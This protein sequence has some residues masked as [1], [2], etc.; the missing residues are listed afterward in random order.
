MNTE[1][2]PLGAVAGC[3]HQGVVMTG[4]LIALVTRSPGPTSCDT[5]VAF[6]IARYA[7]PVLGLLAF[8]VTVFA[9]LLVQNPIA[10]TLE[11]GVFA[12]FLFC[13]IGFVLGS[14]AQMVVREFERKRE[15]EILQ[16]YEPGRSDMDV[17]ATEVQ[18]SVPEAD[19]G[20]A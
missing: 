2:S 6:M 10:T 5:D 18:G 16:R 4:R 8:S 3:R 9:G 14:V 15:A 17:A 13:M 7:G 1:M 12:L 20:G 11:R 19:L